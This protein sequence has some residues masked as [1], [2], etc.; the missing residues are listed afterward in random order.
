[1]NTSTLSLTSALNWVGVS[2]THRPFY[3][4]ERPCSHCIGGWV[5]RCGGVDGCGKF[6]P[7]RVSIPEPS[8]P[9]RVAIPTEL[10]RPTGMMYKHR[11]MQQCYNNQI[12][13]TY[14]VHLLD[15]YSTRSEC[16][17]I[18]KLSRQQANLC[19]GRSIALFTITA[20][21]TGRTYWPVVNI[22]TLYVTYS[23]I[24]GD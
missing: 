13:L 15:K 20:H 18:T 24:Y 6:T 21:P 16:L 3:L 14:S 22:Y 10:S 5:C 9:Y 19:C 7:F 2:T 1:M 23:F 8:S 17:Q 11:N 12:L 4:R